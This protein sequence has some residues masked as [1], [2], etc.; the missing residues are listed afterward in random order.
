MTSKKITDVDYIESLN[1][2]ESFFVNQNNSIKQINRGNIVFGIA[3]G[4]T[5]ASTAA[6][7]LSNLGITATATE[8]NYC[9]GVTSSI[10]TQ[11]NHKMSDN[12]YAI[13][14]NA[15]GESASHGGYIDFHYGGGGDHTSRIIESSSGVV[16]LNNKEIRT[17]TVEMSDGGTGAT[18]GANGLK[19][20]LASGSTILSSYQYGDTL[21]DAGVAGRIFFKKADV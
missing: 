16:M 10:Q 19:N 4:G 12:P 9:D 18:D 11:L 21:P 2:N 14:L 3:N 20:L 6:G 5:G 13:E 1:S 17:G 15:N 8:L 7:A